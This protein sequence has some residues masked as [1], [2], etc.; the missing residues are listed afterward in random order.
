[1]PDFILPDEGD[2]CPECDRVLYVGRDCPC[3]NC[4]A[5]KHTVDE[6]EQAF[7]EMKE[8]DY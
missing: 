4:D 1:M 6:Y 7:P 8:G 5:E 3:G 2:R